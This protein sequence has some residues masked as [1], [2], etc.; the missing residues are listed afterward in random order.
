MGISVVR[1][2][3]INGYILNIESSGFIKRLKVGVRERK[4]SKMTQRVF[5]LSNRKYDVPI[6]RQGRQE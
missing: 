1:S 4:S 3:G 5:V 2:V 6:I